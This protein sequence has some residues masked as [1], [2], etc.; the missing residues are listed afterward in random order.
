MIVWSVWV[1]VH[2][3]STW[4]GEVSKSKQNSTQNSIRKREGG[5]K[6]RGK[7]KNGSEKCES[8]LERGI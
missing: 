8:K 5:V 7:R 1:M 2:A 3:S 6:E 4:L